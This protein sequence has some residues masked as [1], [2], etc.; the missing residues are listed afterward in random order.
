MYEKLKENLILIP[1]LLLAHFVSAEITLFLSQ[2]ILLV[3]A[4]LLNSDLCVSP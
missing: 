1:A 2:S 3:S 4:S